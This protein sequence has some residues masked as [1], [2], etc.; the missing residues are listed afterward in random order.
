MNPFNPLKESVD[1]VSVVIPAYNEETRIAPV[2]KGAK[3]YADEILVVNDNSTDQTARIS[4]EAGAKVILNDGKKGYIEAIKT[5]LRKA[6]FDIIV[7]LDADG[8]HNPAD[9]PALVQPIQKNKAD[10]VLGKRPHIARISERLLSALTRLKVN[11][12]DSGT[13][14]RALRK[15]LAI[16]LKLDGK[17]TCGTFVLEANAYGAKVAE[18]PITLHTTDKPRWIAWHHF[19]QLFYVLK[20]LLNRR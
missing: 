12:S 15:E 2:I 4:E 3:R 1:S 5:E 9:I 11:V 16:K 7:T 13:G 8:E 17:C 6:S 10:L 18:V 19:W 14:F 20:W